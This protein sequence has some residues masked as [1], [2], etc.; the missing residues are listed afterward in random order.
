MGEMSGQMGPGQMGPGAMSPGA[1]GPGQMAPGQMAGQIGGQIGG[2]MAP[3]N[4]PQPGSQ[5]LQR[6]SCAHIGKRRLT[7]AGPHPVPYAC[8][9]PPAV[10]NYDDDIENEPPL[11]EATFARTSLTQFLPFPVQSW[12][13]SAST[14]SISSLECRG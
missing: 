7:R 5:Q 11:L 1:M 3:G 8:L 2:Q 12:R 4:F 10:N 14:L 9:R 6:V 13:S